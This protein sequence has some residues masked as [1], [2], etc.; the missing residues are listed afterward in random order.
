MGNDAID[1]GLIKR[2]I[3]DH[4]IRLQRHH[5]F[6]ISEIFKRKRKKNSTKKKLWTKSAISLSEFTLNPEEKNLAGPLKF[7]IDT[8]HRSLSKPKRQRMVKHHDAS[9]PHAQPLPLYKDYTPLTIGVHVDDDEFLHYLP[10]FGEN[11]EELGLN[12]EE[13]FEDRTG[14]HEFIL[15]QERAKFM[16]TGFF[17][18]ISKIGITRTQLVSFFFNHVNSLSPSL[19]KLILPTHAN[20]TSKSKNDKDVFEIEQTKRVMLQPFVTRLTQAGLLAK[21]EFFCKTFKQ[22]T[23]VSAWDVLATFPVGRLIENKKSSLRSLNHSQTYKF[24]SYSSLMCPLC[25]MHECPW[26]SAES[27]YMAI[28]ADGTFKPAPLVDHDTSNLTTAAEQ[29]LPRDSACSE[30]CFLNHKIK[31]E[32]KKPSK[33]E[34]T[35]DDV[36]LLQ[37]TGQVMK[38]NPRTACMLTTMVDKPCHEI[39][40]KLV[41]LQLT[42]DHATTPTMTKTFNI[43]FAES[44]NSQILNKR[45]R[46]SALSYPDDCSLSGN[47]LRR[48]N[49]SPCM[50]A[51]PCDSTCTCVAS[52]VVC[53]KS[54]ACGKTCPRRWRGCK[55]TASRCRTSS[56]ECFKWNRECDPDLCRS[57]GADQVLEPSNRNNTMDHKYCKNVVLQQ[58]LGK[59]VIAG[60]SKIAGWGLFLGEDIKQDEFLGEYKGEL[61]SQNEA[62]RRGKIYDK[63]G[64]S[65]LFEVTK[66]QCV[67][68]T[69]AGN[70]LRFMNH[71]RTS[72]NCVARVILVNGTHRIAFFAKRRIKKGEELFIDYG[73]NNK[74][75]K[76]VPLE[77]SPQKRAKKI[78]I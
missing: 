77:G 48:G 6:V 8:Y 51:G 27:N 66:D 68:A 76:F 52:N 57:C 7:S 16:S 37:M 41:E 36:Q 33:S 47:H 32:T 3:T 45:K 34:W 40:D 14:I 56:C 69:R 4:L 49:V 42:P 72:P 28:E 59:R 60:P 15:Q 63:R 74:T 30:S 23:K 78:N 19:Q 65:F 75:I 1:R 22:I 67:D 35:N 70:K 9:F 38:V 46:K 54:C 61:I 13:I 5:E 21:V 10:Y 73:Y 18:L 55:C 26:H 12:L 31:K 50:H 53:E 39:H 2:E 29:V 62:E 71:S 25:F 44:Y 20:D 24:D 58:G 43:A 64:V 11:G 17:K